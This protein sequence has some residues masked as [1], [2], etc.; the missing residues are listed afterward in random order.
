MKASS[1]GRGQTVCPYCGGLEA[2][3]AAGRMARSASVAALRQDFRI[4]S[5]TLFA[6]HKLPLR[7]YLAA[8]AIFCNEVK[9]KSMLAI[10]PR[11]GP[12]LQGGVRAC[13]K[14]RE[15][16][17]AETEGPD[18]GRRGQGRRSRW[19]LLRRLRQVPP[20]SVRT[21]ST[22]AGREPKRQAQ[23]VVIIRERDGDSLPAVFN[24][25]APASD[26]SV[27]TPRGP[28]STPTKAASWDDLHAQ[29]EMKR[30]NH[31]RRTASTGPVPIGPRTYF[32]RLRRAEIGHH[33]HIG[34][35]YLLRFAQEAAWRE[36][37]RR[38]CQRR[39]SDPRR[40]PGDGD[41]AISGDFLRLLAAAHS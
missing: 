2:Y 33:H 21:A 32:T 26:S 19:R 5:G 23:V 7:M 13:H 35:P 41:E 3:Q 18:A 30:I 39:A 25:E 9:G 4:T 16:M 31:R 1:P 29:F 22:G 8:I 37:S 40:Q 28:S 10:E 34:G 36:D 12:V 24:S 15:A 11:S 14:M 27:A 17:A 6:S 20:T 38:V